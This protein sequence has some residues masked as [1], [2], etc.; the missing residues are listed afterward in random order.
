MEAFGLSSARPLAGGQ[1]QAFAGDGVVLKP[2]TDPAHASWLAGVLA[3]LP[4]LDDLRVI[5]PVAAR[6]GSWVV[7]GWAAW[8]WLDGEVDARRVDD[9][10]AVSAAFHD[11][12]AGVAP[13]PVPPLDDPWRLGDR[14][15]WEGEHLDTPVPDEVAA[16]R[17]RLV[18]LDL[19]DQLV[20]ADLL[21]NV[22]FAEGMPPAVIDVSPSWRPA[23][24]ADAVV[25]VD[26]VSW[27]EGDLSVLRRADEQLVLRAALFRLGASC[28]LLGDDPAR[29]DAEVAAFRRCVAAS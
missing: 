5:R 29:L 14:F 4:E 10:L 27:W 3:E 21:G 12:V 15:A 23:A 13:P 28:V 6:D 11:L 22:L 24:F 19:P 2:V 20:H 25:C 17:A 26:A 1:G 7:D 8:A 18:P 9:V 16:V